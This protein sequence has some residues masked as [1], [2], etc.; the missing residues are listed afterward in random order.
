MKQIHFFK[1][2]KGVLMKRVTLCASDGRI[3][4]YIVRAGKELKV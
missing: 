2:P 1:H 4:G 3:L